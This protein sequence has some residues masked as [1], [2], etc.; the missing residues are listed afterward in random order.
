MSHAPA[1]TPRFAPVRR[2]VLPL[3]VLVLPL[4]ATSSAHAG[5][6]DGGPATVHAAPSSSPPDSTWPS[7]IRVGERSAVTSPS[8]G[9]L[10]PSCW[11][12]DDNL[13]AAHGD[14]RGFGPLPG[15]DI[16][17]NRI[18]GTPEQDNLAGTLVA[19][20]DQVGQIW[21]GAGYNRKPTGM[22]CVGGDLYLAVQDLK[23][24]TFDS[25]PAATIARSTDHGR[26]WTWHTGEAM[27]AGSVFTTIMF[28]DFG[29]DYADAVDG[30]VYAY[31][32][33]D[34][35]RQQTDVHLG[36]VPKDRIQDR[37][38]WEFYTG[39]QGGRA[40]W[41][42]E[43]GDRA[44]V[45]HDEER[46]YQR[47]HE[48]G[49]HD[50]VLIAQGGVVY[51]KPLGRYLFTTWNAFQWTIYDAPSPWGPWSKIRAKD[52]GVGWTQDKHGG[53]AP[54]IPSKFV[55][56][57]GRTMWAQ[58]N[59][60]GPCGATPKTVYNFNLRELR[61]TPRALSA[62][63]N[64]KDAARNLATDPGTT[65][66]ERVTRAG[67][68]SIYN[69]GDLT[70]SEDDWNNEV[71][72]TSW[73]GYTW[74][75]VRH[76][77]EVRYTT[78][79]MPADGGWYARDLRVQVRRNGRW[80]DVRNQRITPAYPYDRTAGPGRTYTFRFAPAVADGVRVI[81][82]PGG[83]HTFTSVSEVGVHYR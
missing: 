32:L 59:V 14:G 29:K 62:P 37:S 72:S 7:T 33:D 36:R 38:A 3:L 78:G 71:K 67:R 43:I 68:T 46:V 64:R 4:A 75:R 20:G 30:Y 82:V 25:A 51:N 1:R 79:A 47:V 45:I 41:S 18:T 16:G 83:S 2:A 40:T 23:K 42:A 8:G 35:W 24:H 58:S 21:S 69:D 9:D 50:K 17:V 39:T 76:V 27:F 55:S 49:V 63:D 65:P 52:F 77:N 31:G 6:G 34:N 5:S 26:T 54:T 70:A 66:Y 10:W 60:C 81:G 19:K 74:P 56:A 12:D 11:S 15:T 57:D 44:P 28:L 53:Y 13:Y 73:W 22:A 80:T 48:D 61:V